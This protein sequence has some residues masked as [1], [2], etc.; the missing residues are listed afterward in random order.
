LTSNTH[1]CARCKTKPVD[2]DLRGTVRR[3]LERCNDREPGHRN[4]EVWR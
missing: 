2:P 1:S 4:L 3:N